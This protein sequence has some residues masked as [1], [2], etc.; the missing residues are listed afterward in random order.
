[1][2][3]HPDLFDH[4]QDFLTGIVAQPQ[5]ARA[6]LFFKTG[7]GKSL[8]AM[9][10]M[11]ELGFTYVVV[12]APPSTH[13]QWE[14]LAA[15]LN[16]GIVC[17]SHAKFR[18]KSTLLSRK[19][20]II[21]DEFHLLGGQK[22]QGWRKLDTLAR[23]LQ[24]PLFILSA[25]PNYNDAERC[26]CVV[27][28]LSPDQHKGG[29]LQFLYTHCETEMNPFGMEPKV[30]GF[31]NHPD[32]ATFLATQRYVYFL[33][34]DLVYTIDDIPYSEELPDELIEYGYNR[35]KHT[36][37][38]S[39]ME[40]RHTARYQGLVADDGHIRTEVFEGPILDVLFKHKTVLIYCNREQVAQALAYSLDRAGLR[41]AM[42]S[43]KTPKLLKETIIQEF[44]ARVHNILIGTATL[45]TGTDG[46]DRVCDT[47]LIVD[48]T[49]DDA[50]RRQLIGRIMP[51][52][53]F[54][55]T[56]AKKVYRLVPI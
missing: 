12:I 33:A 26:Y 52:G 32:S 37:I 34:D 27:H 51:R 22:G 10:G 56:T 30:I 47:L 19:T 3:D 39:I 40:A 49:E 43:G 50:L 53:D 4:Q 24:A 6:C 11:K 18:M 8:T 44:R 21:C 38:G 15:N 13:R 31:R 7:A 1:M 36:M 45:A 35:R 46:L 41:Y 55:S 9:L 25:T 23:H 5:P 2:A 20:A 16:M 29:Y 28:V 17:M 48:D 42:V 54:V 14:N